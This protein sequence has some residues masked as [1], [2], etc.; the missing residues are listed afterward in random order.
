MTPFK[1]GV[2]CSVAAFGGILDQW[3][4]EADR[5]EIQENTQQMPAR[6]R[7][8]KAPR[9]GLSQQVTPDSEDRVGALCRDLQGRQ[10]QDEGREERRQIN[11]LCKDLPS[12][13]GL[14][15]QNRQDYGGGKQQPFTNGAGLEPGNA[16]RGKAQASTPGEQGIPDRARAKNKD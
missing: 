6:R 5:A 14:Q 3:G 15:Q 13:F 16:K 1:A 4:Q 9:R 7:R 2:R 10:K 11:G 12:V 8:N